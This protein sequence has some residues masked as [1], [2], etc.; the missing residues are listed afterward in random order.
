MCI[1]DRDIIDDAKK[2]TLQQAKEETKQLLR[3]YAGYLS[4]KL[5]F[6]ESY[7]WKKQAITD[8][9]A[10]ATTSK[11]KQVAE[12]ALAALEKKRAEY[13]KLTGN[14]QYDQLLQQYKTYQQQQT[15]IMKTYAAQRVEAEKQGNIAMIAQ[16]NAKEQAELSKLAASRLMASESWN[17]L[18]SDLSTLTTNTIN[19]LITDIN[20]KKVSLSAQFNP[21]RSESH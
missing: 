3:E 5:D 14:E 8:K 7:A 16:I 10:K 12:A 1:R 6:E 21:G 17:Q 20:S 15:E 18:F 2:D 11:D 19:K 13:S 4:D 9:L